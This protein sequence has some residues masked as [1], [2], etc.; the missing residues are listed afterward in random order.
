MTDLARVYV[1]TLV[2]M[3]DLL[4]AYRLDPSDLEG[5]PRA[6]YL[7]LV[8]ARAAGTVTANAIAIE[9]QRAGCV[10]STEALS[11]LASV[12][13]DPDLGPIVERLKELGAVR[14]MQADARALTMALERADL[15][16][17]RVALAKLGNAST[18]RTGA[19][20]MDFSAL[21]A[22]TASAISEAAREAGHLIRLG[23]PSVDRAYRIGPGSMVTIGAQ[24]N[25]GKTTLAWSWLMDLAKR[26]VPCGMISVEDPP[27]D[28]GAKAIGDIASVN[29]AHLWQGA[30][31][32]DWDRVRER[33][34][35]HKGLPVYTAHIPDRGI[36]SVLATMDAMATSHGCK[37]VVVDYL[38]AISHREGPSVRE[39]VDRSLEDLISQAGRSKVGLV[40]L[41]QLAR[42]ERGNPFREPQLIDLKESGSI[43]NRAQCVVMLWRESDSPGPIRA[44]VAK[45]KRQA[46]GARFA[47][48]RH[49]QHAGLVELSEEDNPDN[50]RRSFDA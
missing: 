30:T 9:A 4:D 37:V 35:S 29:P 7:G 18:G 19:A 23:T 40:L 16:A 6:L 14:R 28:M 42:P 22:H 17:A 45:A 1:A 3:P 26:G 11:A 39:R 38:Q 48:V 8:A 46:A 31:Q 25:V 12:L 34:A 50:Y 21:V 13:I 49:P 15:G 47:L 32:A 5:D 36:D 41:S 10:R 27:E 20:I 43:E 24:T 44:K 33:V 2:A